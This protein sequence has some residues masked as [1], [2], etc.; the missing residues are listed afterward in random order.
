MQNPYQQYV[1]QSITTMTQGEMVVRLYE[2]IINQ[3][4]RA[5]IHIDNNSDNDTNECIKK[6]QKILNHLLVTL[7]HKYEISNN[8]DNLYR[9]FI[10]RIIMAN[11][12]K[13]KMII[14]EILPLIIDLKDTFKEGERLARIKQ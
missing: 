12:K 11:V 6:S 9:F 3:L 5:K 2:E 14:D 7:D 4:S 10:Q 1:D 8:L 13:D